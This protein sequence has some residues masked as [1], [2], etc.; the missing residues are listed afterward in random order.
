MLNYQRVQERRCSLLISFDPWQSTRNSQA[1]VGMRRPLCRHV[2]HSC[3]QRGDS[4][5][6]IFL[7][8]EENHRKT[9]QLWITITFIIFIYLYIYIYKI[10]KDIKH[11][12]KIH[13]M[14]ITVMI[15]CLK[16]I[17]K[18]TGSHWWSSGGDLVS[19]TRSDCKPCAWFWKKGGDS[20]Q[21]FFRFR[22]RYLED[23]RNRE[24][25]LSMGDRMG[26]TLWLCQQ[27]ANLKMAQSK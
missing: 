17:K 9:I 18:P 23:H 10:N 16:S 2:D 13:M 12:Y 11:H 8:Y 24:E 3:P 6:H 14:I 19:A 1:I 21:K 7:N 15:G 22:F 4:K 27:F 20:A 5:I 26:M 25:S